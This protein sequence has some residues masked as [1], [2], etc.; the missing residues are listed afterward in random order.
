MAI[1]LL[2]AQSLAQAFIET[3][4]NQR[5]LSRLDQFLHPDFVDYSLPPA[6][7]PD[8]AGLAAWV[9][10]TSASFEHHTTI[11]AQVSEG[12]QTMLKIQMQLRHIGPWRGIEPTGADVTAV[13][14][15]YL[16]VRD[17]QIIGHWALIDGNAIENQL[18][19][20]SRGCRIQA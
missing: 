6:L 17:G 7:A 5:E 3:I 18:L 20:S 1:S 15:R 2:P 19:E 16:Q 13:G 11:E 14:Y 4:W 12:D 9:Q 8:Q 10:A